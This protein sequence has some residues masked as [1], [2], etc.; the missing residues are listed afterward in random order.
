L[1]QLSGL[2]RKLEILQQ[3]KGNQFYRSSNSVLA[4]RPAQVDIAQQTNTIVS[5]TNSMLFVGEFVE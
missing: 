3:Q 5:N 1:V 4:L 2:P